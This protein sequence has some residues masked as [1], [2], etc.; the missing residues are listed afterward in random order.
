[1][2]KVKKHRQVFNR[3]KFTARLEILKQGLSS[4]NIRPALLDLFKGFYQNGFEEI[5]RRCEEGE[6]GETLVIAQSFL[7]DE[8]IVQLYNVT[9]Y[10]FLLHPVFRLRSPLPPAPF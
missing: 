5:K 1:M 7:T 9:A 4:S 8:I 2:I 3:K 6:N 10:I